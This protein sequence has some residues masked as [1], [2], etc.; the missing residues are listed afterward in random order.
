M[1]WVL[2]LPTLCLKVDVTGSPIFPYRPEHS[3]LP[4]P[5]LGVWG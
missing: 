5:H 3:E 1:K 2:S 4:G